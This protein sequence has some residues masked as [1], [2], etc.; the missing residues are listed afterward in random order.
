[1]RS[2]DDLKNRI[3]FST[4]CFTSLLLVPRTWKTIPLDPS[5]EKMRQID[6]GI[7]KAV[8]AI[9]IRDAVYMLKASGTW[10]YVPGNQKH[11]TAGETGIWA[12][13]NQNQVQLRIGISDEMPQG[14]NW[15]TIVGKMTQIDSGPMG[16]LCGITTTEEINCRTGIRLAD[17]PKGSGWSLVAMSK[18]PKYISCGSLGCW[19]VDRA[20]RVFF[21]LGQTS[22]TPT[23][24]SWGRVGGRFVL[25]EAGPQG[26]VW[27]IGR[28][29]EVFTRNGVSE[30]NPT[31]TA[32][33]KVKESGYQ[34]VTVGE[35]GVYA[36]TLDGNVE[37]CKCWSKTT[38]ISLI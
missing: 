17:N 4:F 12:V 7:T 32:W 33:E 11:V 5:I 6:S 37:Y 22:S 16:V 21:R 38:L 9:N 23:G 28:S 31:G 24:T 30:T 18:K 27:G 36:I 3:N 34:H 19:V 10:E 14:K 29:G 15:F 2:G 1:M 13:G 20:G 25:L 35:T 8:W 26:K